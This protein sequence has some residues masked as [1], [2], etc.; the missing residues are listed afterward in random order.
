MD[1]SD[2]ELLNSLITKFEN[3]LTKSYNLNTTESYKEY[4]GSIATGNFSPNF[5]KYS[6]FEEDLKKFRNSNF[7][8]RS[9]VK[10]SSFDKEAVIEVPLTVVNGEI[11]KN[12]VYDPIVL[13]PTGSYVKCLI[14][15]NESKV[16]NDYF[17]VVKAGID[18]SP[19]IVAQTLYENLTAE[20]LNDGLIRLIIAI[21]FHYQIGLLIT[22]K[23]N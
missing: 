17:E 20:E 14:E 15:K 23:E 7:Y 21:N 19:G 1:T 18:I 22:E 4:L 2:I 12:E 3:H 5:F 8:K 11:Q 10:T 6:A 9:W 13:N 16:I